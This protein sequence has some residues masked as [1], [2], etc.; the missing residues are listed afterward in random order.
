MI[1]VLPALIVVFAFVLIEKN[2]NYHIQDRSDMVY[3][4]AAV[5]RRCSRPEP[6]RWE[7][8][9]CEKTY[10]QRG[11]CAY[12]NPHTGELEKFDVCTVQD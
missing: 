1:V 8:D 11:C 6:L 9:Q 2:T 7:Q 5:A 4:M 3:C 12:R 10:E